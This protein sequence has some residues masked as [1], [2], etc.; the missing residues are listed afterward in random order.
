MRRPWRYTAIALFLLTLLLGTVF[1][2]RLQALDD[3]TRESM[4][5]Y[6]ELLSAAHENYGAE[7]NYRDLVYASIQGVTRTLDPHTYFLAP[8][9]YDGMRERQ[10]SSF[11]GLGILVGQRNGRVTVITPI[12]GG[13]ASR[14]GVQAGDIIDTIDGESTEPL[15]LDDAVRKL[16]GP[17]GSTVTITLLRRGL[18]KPLE[19]K[20]VRAEIPLT[21]V[22]YSYML[23]PDTAYMRITDFNRGTGDEVTQELA[24]LKEM[25]MKRLLLDLRNN[26]GGLLDQAIEVGE[27]FV[28]Q[29]SKIV[30]TRGRTRSSYQTFY[31]NGA[32]RG[33]DIPVVVLVNSGTA[34]AAE[35]LA[36]AIQDHD[37]GVIAGTPTWGKGLVQTVYSLSYGAGLALT[38]AKYYTPSGRLIQRDYSSY[39]DYYAYNPLEAGPEIG[40]TESEPET[41]A[42]PRDPEAFQTDLGRSVYGGGGIT[43]DVAIPAAP[44]SSFLQFLH[45]R[46]AF[47]DFAVEYERKHPPKDE[48]WKPGKAVLDEFTQWLG[49]E[50][51]GEVDEMKTSLADEE[52]AS[53]ALRQIRAEVFNA[54]FGQEAW[55][56]VLASGDPQI[57]AGLGLFDRAAELLTNR[58]RIEDP[59]RASLEADKGKG[60]RGI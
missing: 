40:G 50:D 7:V 36:G 18:D 21:T 10:K 59:Q 2:G 42:S 17:K 6:T 25:G 34:S 13:P 56:R 38:T 12:E 22:R 20:V 31:G 19:M 58:N 47:F 48:G 60:G 32:D 33:L 46:N 57:E 52:T 1:G 23:T 37:I 30:E 49:R 28:P 41:P 43:P 14:L 11:Y 35:I 54:A 39:F 3:D 24:R 4:R 53:Y 15:S 16:K 8:Q 27:Q 29:G 45:T 5:L 44:I 9:A 55:H 26:G 51:L